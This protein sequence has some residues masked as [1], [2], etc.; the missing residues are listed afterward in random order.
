MRS[1]ARIRAV[2]VVE[3]AGTVGGEDMEVMVVGLLVEVRCE[4]V[5]CGVGRAQ[6]P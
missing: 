3:R 5:M 1:R 6:P 4:V 2:R